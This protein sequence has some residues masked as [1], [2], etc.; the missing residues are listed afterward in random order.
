MEVNIK[1]CLEGTKEAEGIS[2]IIDVFRASNTI[3]ACL[4]QGAE[5]I[6]PVGGLDEAYNLKKKN[7]A[8]LLVG[9]RKGLLPQGFDYG[10]SPAK[11]SKLDL[12]NKRIILTT[13]A[14]SQGI[15]NANK[16]DEILIGSFVN[17]NAIVD[18][19]KSRNPAKVSLVAIGFEAHKKA[20]E[21]ELCAEYIKNQ[22]LGIKSDFES[23]KKEILKSDGAD[24]L[25]RLNQEDDLEFSLRLDI[26]DIVPKYDFKSRRIVC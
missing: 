10:N 19:I 20:K 2:V 4:C 6:I 12:S 16:S 17:A 21:D 22:L 5:Y 7:P 8:H 24:R 13:S 23:M 3:I 14:G 18:Y 9:E 26:C 25:R 11:S 1:S 15:V